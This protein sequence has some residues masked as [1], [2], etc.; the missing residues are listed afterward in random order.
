VSGQR[1]VSGARQQAA[2]RANGRAR[3]AQNAFRHGLSLPVLA[4]PAAGAQA[5]ALAREITARAGAA[6][7]SP[8][9]AELGEA[10]R[11]V[12][13]AQLDLVRV[14]RARHDLIAAALADPDYA[15]PRIAGEQARLLAIATEIARRPGPSPPLLDHIIALLREKPQGPGKLALILADLAPRLAAMDRYERRARSRRKLAMRAYDEERLRLAIA[16]P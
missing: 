6:E 11:R 7:P 4:D 9:A 14:R 13:E 15:S 2:R 16:Q 12:A 3:S 5:A 1:H 8:A 10:S